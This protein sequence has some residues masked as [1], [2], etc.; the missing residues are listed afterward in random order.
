[1]L[2]VSVDSRLREG[3]AEVVMSKMVDVAATALV[4]YTPLFFFCTCLL[5]VLINICCCGKSKL[6]PHPTSL[7]VKLCHLSMHH[8]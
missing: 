4:P 1:M 3:K 6:Y 8:D 5:N 2:E 7:Q